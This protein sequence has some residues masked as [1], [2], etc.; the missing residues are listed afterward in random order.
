MMDATLTAIA[1][2]PTAAAR[3]ARD[4]SP[5]YVSAVYDSHFDLSLLGKSLRE[6]YKRLGGPEAFGATLTQAQ[7][8]ALASAY[9]IP[10]VR[11]QPH[12]G[13]AIERQ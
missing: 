8:D 2:G 11:L 1:T 4:S 9:S 5:V 6:A 3:F 10:A 12:P 7:V 13:R